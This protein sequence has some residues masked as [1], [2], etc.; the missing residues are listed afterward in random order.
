[1][2]MRAKSCLSG[3]R[4]SVASETNNKYIVDQNQ[5]SP[6]KK[7]N[8]SRRPSTSIHYSRKVS[9]ANLCTSQISP[10]SNHKKMA[11]SPRPNSKIVTVADYVKSKSRE[12]NLMH[13]TKTTYGT[14]DQQDDGNNHYDSKQLLSTSQKKLN[15]D[16]NSIKIADENS[17]KRRNID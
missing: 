14:L 10:R 16:F 13:R 11:T 9:N 5:K 8:D 3:K 15:Y 4:Y 7:A 2:K 6:A 17:K 12:P 1:M